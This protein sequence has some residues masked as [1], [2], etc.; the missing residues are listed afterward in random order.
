MFH[1]LAFKQVH[2]D[3][4]LDVFTVLRAKGSN[5]LG[6]LTEKIGASYCWPDGSFIN[7]RGRLSTFCIFMLMTQEAVPPP[8][9]DYYTYTKQLV[10]V[11]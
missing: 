1:T 4:S 7:A 8:N 3:L 10:H 2:K 9:S 11:D 6:R 5:V